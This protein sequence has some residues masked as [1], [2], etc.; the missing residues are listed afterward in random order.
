VHVGGLTFLVCYPDHGMIYRFIP[1]G[2]D[3]CEMELTWLVRKD[4]EAGRDYDLD[5]LTWLW[6]VTTEQDKRIIE[7]TS[8][9]VR[10]GF[11]TPG[12][13]A[14]ME[15]NELRYIAWYLDELGRG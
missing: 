4:A 15:R 13:L 8:R 5:R 11:F 3:A 10:S 6:K 2:V 12:P 14:P 9:G 1:K 7:P